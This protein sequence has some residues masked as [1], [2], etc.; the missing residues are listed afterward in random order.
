[1]N[2]KLNIYATS[3]MHG[4]LVD[5]DSIPAC[6]VFI[7]GGDS[8]LW[9]TSHDIISQ[10]IWLGMV[11]R[12]WLKEVK[13]KANEVILIAG[14]H[15]FV[16]ETGDFRY[17]AKDYLDCV[18]LQDSRFDYEGVSF[19]GTPWV[20]RLRSWAF[21]GNE[22]K[23]T[24]TFA[25]IPQDIDVLVSH[26]P[27]VGVNDALARSIHGE[28]AGSVEL[29]L[30]FEDRFNQDNPIPVNIH[31]HIHEGYGYTERWGS[32]LYNVSHLNRDYE[33]TNDIVKIEL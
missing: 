30:V 28:H 2:Q 5:P 6:D 29:A 24:N 4:E 25:N 15:D 32:K 3:D 27:P 22:E 17:W 18:Y 14:N 33:P 16:F 11:F 13:E 23:L 8:C 7:I 19:Y 31:G 20:P 26:G 21:Y 12:P 9:K 10:S 1:M